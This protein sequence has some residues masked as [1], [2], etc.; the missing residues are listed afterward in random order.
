[1][2][3]IRRF[4]IA[5]ALFVAP[6][7]LAQE[8]SDV[9]VSD[10]PKQGDNLYTLG[11]QHF[12]RPQDY[13]L[14]RRLN[15][16]AD[17]RRMPVGKPIRI[18]RKLLRHEPVVARV[19]SARGSVFFRRG[20]AQFTLKAGDQLGERDEIVTAASSFVSLSLPDESVVSLPSRSHV[21]IGRLRKLTLTGGVERLFELVTGRTRAIVTP[22]KKEDD[23]RIRTPVVTSAVRGT[24][25]RAGYDGARATVEVLEGSVAAE[26]N[27]VAT[28]VEAGRGVVASTD[29]V[30]DSLPLLPP[31]SLIDPAKVQDEETLAFT[32]EPVEGAASYH[33]QIAQDAGFIDV[34]AE[35]YSFVPNAT[36]PA[37]PNGN[38]F[39]RTSAIDANGLEG[40]HETSSF[41][42]R[43][44][45]IKTAFETRMSDRYREY[46]FRW[47]TFGDGARQFRFQ[48]WK[49][50]QAERPMV[51][52]PGI[53]SE[54]LVLT[55]LPAGFYEWRVRTL[56][57]ADGKAYEK[58]SA[59]ER[60]TVHAS[61]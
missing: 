18:P 54:R 8:G 17:P 10:A 7:A 45:Q 35:T 57:F 21:R 14:V 28:R 38:W 12:V 24:E 3:T 20:G 31:P 22:M 15:R 5:L 50:G 36:L 51:D 59:V 48:L 37:L 6:P 53:V 13:A 26:Q 43:L 42:R 39:V 34:V 2:T 46:L 40:M 9:W 52:L 11:T 56:L 19:L 33:V 55:D 32:L 61:R 4:F 16:I 30:S 60:F 29:T 23:F 47:Q 27:S 1:M 25:Y 41:E 49:E 44:N 58:W